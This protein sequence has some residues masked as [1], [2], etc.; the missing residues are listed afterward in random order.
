MI[1]QENKLKKKKKFWKINTTGK[2]SDQKKINSKKLRPQETK[3]KKL[4]PQQ[5]KCKKRKKFWIFQKKK[6]QKDHKKENSKK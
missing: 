4:R 2:K 5:N 3:S 1:P 6:I